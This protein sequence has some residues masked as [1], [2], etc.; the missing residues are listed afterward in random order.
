MSRPNAKVTIEVTERELAYLMRVTDYPYGNFSQL[1][2]KLGDAAQQMREAKRIKNR[3]AKLA[4]TEKRKA[5][6]S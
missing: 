4:R 6:M 1:N 5:A 2:H 3:E